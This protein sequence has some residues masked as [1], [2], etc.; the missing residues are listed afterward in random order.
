MQIRLT[1]VDSLLF[2]KII[3]LTSK[4][5]EIFFFPPF[6]FFIS[7]CS[8]NFLAVFLVISQRERK[9]ERRYEYIP[10]YLNIGILLHVRTIYRDL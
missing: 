8:R 7:R 5:V 6:N 1:S 9:G 4:E 2:I 10:S 3:Q